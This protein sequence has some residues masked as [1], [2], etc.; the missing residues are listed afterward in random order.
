M[1]APQ[2][3]AT[4]DKMIDELTAKGWVQGRAITPSGA[5]CL[6][7]CLANVT[8]TVDENYWMTYE[9]L[10]QRVNAQGFARVMDFN[11]DEH[12]TLQDV[13]ELLNSR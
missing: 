1:A 9:W 11:D 12:T 7:A 10:T 2:V 13:M 5:K 6:M 4:L 8:V 3:E